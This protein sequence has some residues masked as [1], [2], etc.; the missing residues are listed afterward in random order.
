[1]LSAF[2]SSTV[3]FFARLSGLIA[4][5]PALTF[6][7]FALSILCTYMHFKTISWFMITSWCSSIK[8]HM[9]YAPQ[10]T[11]TCSH[12]VP[13]GTSDHSSPAKPLQYSNDVGH[14]NV[15]IFLLPPQSRG[16]PI[17][18]YQNSITTLKITPHYIIIQSKCVKKS[19]LHFP[20]LTFEFTHIF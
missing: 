6:S 19:A 2:C 12:T 13:I 18:L 10:G 20:C 8:R 17:T 3:Q 1:M 15:C 5:D 9:H 7:F 11:R 4:F 16:H 14:N